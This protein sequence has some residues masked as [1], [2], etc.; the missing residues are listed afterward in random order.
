M[1]ETISVDDFRAEVR[2]WL[3]A[4]LERKPAGAAPRGGE[5]VT[6]EEVAASRVIQR[7]M[8]DAGYAGI[9]FPVEYGGRGLTADH[10]RVWREET[11]SHVIP[12]FGGAGSVTMGPI[13][14][15]MLAHA[16]PQF[17]ARHIPK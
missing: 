12:A 17:L 2:A 9:S 14:R 3:E 1:T 5:A 4:N 13:A 10:A 8:F 11:R 16:T 15:S 6:D 7:K